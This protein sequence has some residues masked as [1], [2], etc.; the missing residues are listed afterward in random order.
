M[1]EGY[2][3]NLSRELADIQQCRKAI[4]ESAVHSA[5]AAVPRGRTAT[6]PKGE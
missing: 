3:Q 2:I 6:L 1:E 4:K 5:I